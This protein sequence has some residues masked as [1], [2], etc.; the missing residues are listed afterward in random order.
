MGDIIGRVQHTADE[1]RTGRVTYSMED[2]KRIQAESFHD[3]PVAPSPVRQIIETRDW[4][5]NTI[6]HLNGFELVVGPHE[7]HW[8]TVWRSAN[9]YIRDLED[10]KTCQTLLTR[11]RELMGGK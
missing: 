6:L 4:M 1:I 11:A 10:L 5:G 8:M 3:V 2:A 9:P 7:D